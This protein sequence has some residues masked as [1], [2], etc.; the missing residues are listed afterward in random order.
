MDTELFGAASSRNDI[1]VFN[2]SGLMH[3]LEELLLPNFAMIGGILPALNGDPIFQKLNH[4]TKIA[5]LNMNH[6]SREDQDFIQR[7]NFR[8]SSVWQPI[9]HLYGLLYKFVSVNETAMTFHFAT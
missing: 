1:S 3:C 8:L 6:F 4:S 2:L 9:E 7:L 5:H